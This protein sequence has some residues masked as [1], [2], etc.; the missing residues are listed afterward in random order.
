[1]R[2]LEAC[3][4]AR[5]TPPSWATQ[6]SP[7]STNT[8][9]YSASARWDADGGVDR[10]VAGG[11]RGRRRTR[12]GTAGAGALGAAAVAG[13][14]RPLHD[15]GQVD[16]REDR[17]V[18]VG[19][20][21]AQD[22]GLVRGELLRLRQAA[23]TLH[24]R[25]QLSPASGITCVCAAAAAAQRRRQAERVTAGGGSCRAARPPP[26][27]RRRV[28]GSTSAASSANSRWWP[29]V[30]A[31]VHVVEGARDEPHAASSAARS[32]GSIS[33]LRDPSGHP[34]PARRRLRRAPSHRRVRRRRGSE[35]TVTHATPSTHSRSGRSK[36][37]VAAV[38]RRLCSCGWG[39]WVPVGNRRDACQR[40]REAHRRI[41]LEDVGATVVRMGP[42]SHVPTSEPISLFI[43]A[44]IGPRHSDRAWP[45][46]VGDRS[47]TSAPRPRLVAR[48]PG[49][50]ITS[51]DR[52]LAAERCPQVA[53]G[54]NT[55]IRPATT[56]SAAAASVSTSTTSGVERP[57]SPSPG[58]GGS[59]WTGRAAGPH[60][61]VGHHA[62]ERPLGRLPRPI[63]GLAV[64]S[65]DGHLAGQVDHCSIVRTKSPPVSSSSPTTWARPSPA[66]QA[67]AA[68]TKAGIGR[69]VLGQAQRTL[70][71]RPVLAGGGD[72]TPPI[73]GGRSTGTTAAPAAPG[74]GARTRTPTGSPASVGRVQ[75]VEH[76][77]R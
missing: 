68:A 34:R 26:S 11:C 57:L 41:D 72:P 49:R 50:R 29:R 69:A 52:R 56:R 33:P 45:R 55:L 54:T 60:H 36:V 17:P 37:Q 74:C 18:E 10:L 13:E 75:A 15:L 16:K 23:T 63:P 14:Q 40:A 35:R 62:P 38:M 5:W 53:A 4:H 19:E 3:S 65:D 43:T 46:R 6:S 64:R 58:R 51:T 27:G 59:S 31:A 22:V 47:G 39:R 48:R 76:G 7:Y 67:C 42:G 77:R 70:V 66:T 32:G 1:M 20:V 21:A 73:T 44:T 61:A 2:T 12:R 28:A 71:G 25:R 8:F 30:G 24:S 9:S